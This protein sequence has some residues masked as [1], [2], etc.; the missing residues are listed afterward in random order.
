MNSFDYC[1]FDDLR[2]GTVLDL[3]DNVIGLTFT[4]EQASYHGR[5]AE[6]SQIRQMHYIVKAVTVVIVGVVGQL[7]AEL[8]ALIIHARPALSDGHE[9]YF[10]FSW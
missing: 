6:L 2:A 7:I 3:I 9:R 10:H 1:F 4:P 5:P 8:L